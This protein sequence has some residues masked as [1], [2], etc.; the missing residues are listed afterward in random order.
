MKTLNKIKTVLD[1]HKKDLRARYKV[2]K[3]G[4]FGSYVRGEQGKKSDL[5][6][7][8]EFSETPGLFAFIELENYISEML[9]TKIDLVMK[10][11]LKP[12]IGK[13]ILK[14]VVYL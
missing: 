9:D 14:E 3:I 10:D 6:I 8:V 1:A 4:I 13:H 5:D 7:L 11:A 2:K 12:H